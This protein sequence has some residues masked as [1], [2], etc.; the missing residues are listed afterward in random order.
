MR[1][2]IQ[3]TEI[4]SQVEIIV[5]KIEAIEFENIEIIKL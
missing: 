4:T 2:R 3:S 5:K 1:E